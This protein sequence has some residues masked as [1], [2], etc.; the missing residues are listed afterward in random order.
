MT[1]SERTPAV[2]AITLVVADLEASTSL[3]SS[4]FAAPLIFENEDSAVFRFEPTAINLLH[5]SADE[6]FAPSPV[7]N[8]GNAPRAAFTVEVTDT[9]R[10]CVEL[11]ERGITL[12][13]GPIT[14]P[15][16]PRTAS[17]ADPDGHVWEI[18]S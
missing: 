3:Y 17:V 15:W 10:Y 7:G 8:V 4:A 12:L 5:R 2:G 14:R 9:D 13:N 1:E 18:A 6:L 16:G 11:A